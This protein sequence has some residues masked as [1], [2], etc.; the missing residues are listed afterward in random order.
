MLWPQRNYNIQTSTVLVIETGS[1]F[2]REAIML[3]LKQ[4]TSNIKIKAALA[5][6]EEPCF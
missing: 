6:F 4:L 5:I 1:N 3:Q 2:E